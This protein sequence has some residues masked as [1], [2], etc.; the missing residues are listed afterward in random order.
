MIL[1]SCRWYRGYFCAWEVGA[2]CSVPCSQRRM[3]RLHTISSYFSDFSLTLSPRRTDAT[4]GTPPL[5][6]QQP[7]TSF[8]VSILTRVSSQSSKPT[9][10]NYQHS[11]RMQLQV[12]WPCQHGHPMTPFDPHAT[13]ASSKIY[14]LLFG[15]GS[16]ARDY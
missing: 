8:Q 1:L 12:P 15:F 9:T 2:E 6:T 11:S 14:L 4:A 5:L 10:S 13:S 16:A 7:S 3:T